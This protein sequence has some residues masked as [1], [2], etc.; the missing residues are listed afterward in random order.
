MKVG[1]EFP[2]PPREKLDSHFW[3]IFFPRSYFI[4]MSEGGGWVV[5]YM[6]NM[7]DSAREKTE[8]LLLKTV[9]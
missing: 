5:A 1:Y 3:F 2:P 8:F 4:K 7:V 9:L 6:K